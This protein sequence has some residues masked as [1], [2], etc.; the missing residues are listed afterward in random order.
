MNICTE[1]FFK[2]LIGK[3]EHHD[4]LINILMTY[5]M[6]KKINDGKDIYYKNF[7]NAMLSQYD[8]KNMNFTK[9]LRDAILCGF[10]E[11]KTLW[12]IID[13]AKGQKNEIDVSN[14]AKLGLIRKS[15]SNGNLNII[16]SKSESTLN[17]IRATKTIS[18][19]LNNYHNYD[20]RNSCSNL[21]FGKKHL[22][23]FEPKDVANEFTKIMSEAIRSVHKYELCFFSILKKN[24]WDTYCKKLKKTYILSEQIPLMVD[25]ILIDK[26]FHSLSFSFKI[27]NKNYKFFTKVSKELLKLK[28]YDTAFIILSSLNSPKFLNIISE[29][30]RKI[31]SNLI[32]LFSSCDSYKKYHDEIEKNKKSL[33]IPII[34]FMR[35]KIVHW[36]DDYDDYIGKLDEEDLISFH[37]IFD[38]LYEHQLDYEIKSKKKLREI[39]DNLSYEK[40]ENYEDTIWSKIA[41]ITG[42]PLI[43]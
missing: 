17:A 43:I 5:C 25:M 15:N 37:K 19:G 4:E 28:N 6:I 12:S 7:N 13:K 24:H 23:D 29:K 35:T 39:I 27:A 38:P 3:K 30:N 26:S 36:F 22:I 21:K 1:E 20:R 16:K 34:V 11:E 42:K 14:D 9:I 8:G 2:N 40:P 41:K 31:V 18:E 33:I 10:I 32:E